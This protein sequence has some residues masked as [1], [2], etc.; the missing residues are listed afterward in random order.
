MVQGTK[1]HLWFF[2]SLL[3]SMVISAVFLKYKQVKMLITFSIILYVFGVLARA[4]IN[5]PIGIVFDFD[6]RNGP[7]FC[8]LPFVTGFVL[9]GKIPKKQWLYLGF[10]LLFIGI[11][12]H[13]SEILIIWKWYQTSPRQEYVFGTYFY[14]LGISLIALSNHPKLQSN[15]FSEIGRFTLGIYAIHYIFVEI[16]W[17][18][19][20]YLNSPLWDIVFILLVLLLSVLSVFA[21]SKNRWTKKLVV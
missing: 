10:G 15:F 2:A 19:F 1:F 9:S 6:T 4:Y 12:I 3:I 5:T 16:F 7:F 20:R 18:L 17:S 21:L 8:T 14:G 13:I 11:L